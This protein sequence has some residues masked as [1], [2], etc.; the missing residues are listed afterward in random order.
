MITR[1]ASLL[2]LLGLSS[3]SSAPSSSTE[4]HL[5][6]Y[7]IHHG[8][9]LDEVLD[10]QRIAKVIDCQ[11]A[12]WVAVQEVDAKTSRSKG[13]D[14][15]AELSKFTRMKGF[16]GKSID[17]AGGGYGN[18]V[19][20]HWDTEMSEV[21]PLPVNGEPRSFLY[22]RVQIPRIGTTHLIATHLDSDWK[23]P[24]G[25]LQQVSALLEFA[26]TLPKEEPLIL[27]G[28]LNATPEAAEIRLLLDA[29]WIDAT[30]G[31][32][33]T[34][35]ADKPKE[36]IDYI[37]IRPGAFTCRVL[38]ASV[39]AEAVASDHRPVFARIKLSR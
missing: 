27:A 12:D 33:A 23:S 21:H 25:R 15:S 14:Q 37:L 9:G 26:A 5:M 34:C 1:L 2:V 29:G 22:Q 3:C 18:A 19:L 35:P 16:F 7:N 24:A 6:S 8:A 17:F 39:P 10:L 11:K 28:D 32:P 36:R 13:L 30:A 4:L 38:E 20:S 31:L